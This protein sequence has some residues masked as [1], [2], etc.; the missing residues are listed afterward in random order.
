MLQ[1]TILAIGNNL[2]FSDTFQVSQGEIVSLGMF[3]NGYS[4]SLPL[5]NFD[6]LCQTPDGEINIGYINSRNAMRVLSGPGV[7]RVRRPSYQGIAMGVF[8]N[9]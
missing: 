3:A 1:T 5:I 7:Y 9:R 6:I 8:L 4:A 2:P